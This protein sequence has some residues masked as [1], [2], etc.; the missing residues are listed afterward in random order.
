MP[1]SPE[2][3]KM[4]TPSEYPW[5]R[6]AFDFLRD[7]LPD[8]EPYRAWV[9]F[10]FVADDGSIH[11]V[12]AL[13]VTPKGFYLLEAKSR[14]GVI[15]GDA[16]SWT[17]TNAGQRTTRDNPLVATDRKAKR[18]KSLL[19]RQPS[20]KKH[21]VPFLQPV[22]F[23]SAPDQELRL[24]PHAGRW[25]FARDL[26]ASVHENRGCLMQHVVRYSGVSTI[27]LAVAS[28]IGGCATQ[29][30]WEKWS[31]REEISS[32]GLELRTSR[33]DDVQ[34]AWR[35][36]ISD[37]S[38][39]AGL[40]TIRPQL[41]DCPE[42]EVLV[43]RHSG[44]PTLVPSE[45]QMFETPTLTT[46]RPVDV[47]WSEVRDPTCKLLLMFRRKETNLITVSASWQS[48]PSLSVESIGA[49]RQSAWL[50]LLPASIVADVIVAPVVV[51]VWMGPDC[52][53]MIDGFL[54]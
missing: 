44:A 23:C 26:D 4:I 45:E 14:P 9:N 27:L 11:Q 24:E 51:C 42:I 1:M 31:A 35:A 20:M 30:V 53:K 25:V 5:E 2:R 3:W 18:L 39:D 28:V 16:H 13:I 29:A 52:G 47:I 41:A 17:W 54:P 38:D 48:Q 49:S 37:G 40:L 50:A 6:E 12:D 36:Q 43:A 32:I 7:G 46:A 33:P 10:D 34:V 22:V 21:R 8:H 19:A 15:A